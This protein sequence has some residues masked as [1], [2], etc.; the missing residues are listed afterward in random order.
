MYLFKCLGVTFDFP[1]FRTESQNQ[2]YAYSYSNSDNSFVVES[3]MNSTLFKYSINKSV[4]F[5]TSNCI[6]KT[7][8][9]YAV[10]INIPVEQTGS[11]SNSN[12]G[13]TDNFFVSN[14]IIILTLS[15]LSGPVGN[16]IIG[17]LQFNKIF[18]FLSLTGAE[19][20]QFFEYINV[21]LY[22]AKAPGTGF[23][24]S[25]DQ[26]YEYLTDFKNR[27]G[28]KMV[29][30]FTTFLF[31][32]LLAFQQLLFLVGY[33]LSKFKSMPKLQSAKNFLIQ[34]SFKI[35][36]AA[37]YR[38]N[39]LFV[40][41]LGFL[42]ANITL[43]NS[44]LH[45]FVYISMLIF[46]LYYPTSLYDKAS[47]YLRA[48]KSKVNNKLSFFNSLSSTLE[49]QLNQ[50][51]LWNRLFDEFFVTLKS[52]LLYQSRK[53][54][55]C[56]LITAFVLTVGEFICIFVF[57]KT[58]KKSFTVIKLVGVALFAVF[59]LMMIA[60][61]YDY[62]ILGAVFEV[63]YLSSNLTKLVEVL[64]SSAFVFKKNREYSKSRKEVKPISDVQI[65]YE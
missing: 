37:S 1:L 6:L 13:Q 48:G 17:F 50:S 47:T 36:R 22:K 2:N 5:N 31:V 62:T 61:T 45:Q 10:M 26:H 38:Y 18:A 4:V 41:N 23:Y 57:Y 20:G 42:I 63:L 46:I 43:I 60:A 19:G 51:L 25:K 15:I 29:S 28:D 24:L 33:I 56:L 16:T 3:R 59:I 8:K 7:T 14:D 12:E 11:T 39:N 53:F 49:W 58:I 34:L 35:L 40:A 65:A 44:G 21:N 27:D 52:F 32:G 64:L 9:V 30:K 54:D 55:E